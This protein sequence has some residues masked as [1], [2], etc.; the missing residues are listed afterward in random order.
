MRQNR[1]GEQKSLRLFGRFSIIT[2]VCATLLYGGSFEDFKRGQAESF[3]KFQ[4]ERDNAF[5]NYLK[6]E[7]KAYK[8]QQG[9]SIYE[10]PKPKTIPTTKPLKVKAVGP[11]T[12]IKIKK[13]QEKEPQIVQKEQVTPK[14]AINFDFY[15]SALGFDIPDGLSTAKFMPHTQKGISSFFEVAASSQYTDLVKDLQNVSNSMNLNDW[16]VYLLV[17]K[18]S[19]AVFTNPDESKLLSWFLFNKLGFNVKVGLA[20]KHIVLM[21]YSKK[22]IYSTPNYSFGDKK[23]YVVSNYDKGSVGT[24]YS[25]DHD[26]PDADK[27]L[28]LS[29]KTLPY[30]EMA[31]KKKHLEFEH[32]KKQYTLSYLYNQNLIDFMS[33]YPQADYETY[34]NA[35]LEGSTYKSIATEL[36]K[37]LDGKQVSESMNFVLNF[38]QNAFIYERDDQQFG[39]E[40]VMFA[41]ETLYYDKSDCEDRAVLYS[42]LIRELFGVSVVGVKY[43]DHMATAMNVPMQ[44]DSIKKGSKTFIIA[45][46]TYI[47]ANIGQSMPQY[48]SVKPE[49]IIEIR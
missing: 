8:E 43:K 12:I 24:L 3:Q 37:Y 25:Y 47:N 7:F 2:I 34:F 10:K 40:K 1:A 27:P 32:F 23:F 44:G 15:G 5:N 16:G 17:L 35:P 31:M 4:D 29:M 21:H 46:P 39:R 26:Y 30:F 41:E 22:T 6:E 20:H 9:I 13:P 36:K 18:Y 19:D 49:E 33:T 11:K 14:K 28:D 42:Y 48:K 45:D 38:V